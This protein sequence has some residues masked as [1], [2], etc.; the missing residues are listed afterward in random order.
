MRPSLQ[1]QA[2]RSAAEALGAI[3]HHL[4]SILIDLKSV[5]AGTAIISTGLSK[6]PIPPRK[7]TIATAQRATDS[8][9][10]TP[11]SQMLAAPQ[12]LADILSELSATRRHLA[13]VDARLWWLPKRGKPA[14]Q[15]PASAPLPTVASMPQNLASIAA[16]MRLM[17]DDMVTMN[18]RLAWLS[19]KSRNAACQGAPRTHHVPAQS[20]QKPTPRRRLPARLQ[21][22]ESRCSVSSPPRC[23]PLCESECPAAR[24][25]AGGQVAS[26]LHSVLQA[27]PSRSNSCTGSVTSSRS[28]ST[29][30]S[31][32]GGSR[33]C[34]RSTWS[35]SATCGCSYP[36][37]PSTD[38]STPVCVR[39]TSTRFRKGS[40]ASAWL[41]HAWV[42]LRK[43]FSGPR[44][45]AAFPRPRSPRPRSACV[46]GAK[47]YSQGAGCDAVEPGSLDGLASWNRK[48]RVPMS[49]LEAVKGWRSY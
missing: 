32:S 45:P 34:S 10:Q 29:E 40:R 33:E 24:G 8:A 17:R 21:P 27:E 12:T 30:E 39:S 48:A 28:C 36:E 6:L 47:H 11:V 14:S 22:K 18:R 46:Q 25:R 2:L 49:D 1:S 42:A 3:P 43:G 41:K 4:T 23:A 15:P 5:Q 20:P 38:P 7:R 26:P 44:S 35:S 37:D 16:E 31:V 9:Q 19:W 13:H